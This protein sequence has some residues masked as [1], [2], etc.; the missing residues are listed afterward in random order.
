MK[1]RKYTVAY[2]AFI[3]FVEIQ[4]PPFWPGW[5]WERI[6]VVSLKMHYINFVMNVWLKS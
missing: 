6:R 3:R 2:P 4:N 5:S 1:T